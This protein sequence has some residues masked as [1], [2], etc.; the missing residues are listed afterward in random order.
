MTGV[1]AEPSDSANQGIDS[2]HQAQ[3]TDSALL[4][5]LPPAEKV[6]AAAVS[7]ALRRCYTTFN[8]LFLPRLHDSSQQKIY[9]ETLHESTPQEG[10]LLSTRQQQVLPFSSPPPPSSF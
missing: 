6:E 5:S 9:T 2:A 7:L 10:V 4:S 8:L 3:K 1:S